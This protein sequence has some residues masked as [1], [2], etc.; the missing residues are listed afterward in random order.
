MNGTA[1]R[2]LA[3]KTVQKILARTIFERRFSWFVHSEY[4]FFCFLFPSPLKYFFL[5]RNKLTVAMKGK[6]CYAKR[7]TN[8]KSFK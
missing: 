2:E 7:V 6:L 8:V 5:N 3:R 4:I 1:H